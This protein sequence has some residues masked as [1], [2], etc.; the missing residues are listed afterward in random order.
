MQARQHDHG[1][2]TFLGPTGDLGGEDI[3]DIAV[4]QAASARFV[5]ARVWS[6]LAY[7]VTPDDAVVTDLVAA[8]LPAMDIADLLRAVFQHPAFRSP[9]ARSGLVKQPI[10]YVVGAARALHLDVDLRKRRPGR[11]CPAA[12]D[13]AVPRATRP[14]RPQV[15]RHAWRP[16]WARRCS[17]LPTWAA[18]RR[19]ATGSTPAPRSARWRAAGLLAGRADLSAIAGVA[20]AGRPDAV[21]RMLGID[22][23]GQTTAA[24]LG[25]LVA[26]PVGLVALALNAP[27]YILN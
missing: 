18:G 12:G 13:T 16:P 21:A 9:A 24:A 20:P 4:H 22:G 7:P 8:Y 27:E 17:T 14:S 3:I 10:E 11:R 2:K 25:H 26:D 19:T 6:H 15:P 23:W 1:A 5:V